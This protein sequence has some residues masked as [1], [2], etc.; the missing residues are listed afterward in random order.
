MMQKKMIGKISPFAIEKI[1]L[2]GTI[3]YKISLNPLAVISE[4][5][6]S[7]VRPSSAPTPGFMIFTKNKPVKIAIRLD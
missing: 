4:V 1:R 2:F 3:L 5:L 6:T 7:A